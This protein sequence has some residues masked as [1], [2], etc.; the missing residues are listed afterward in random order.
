MNRYYLKAI[1][2]IFTLIALVGPAYCFGSN[3]DIY[4]DNRL[5]GHVS[6]EILNITFVQFGGAVNYEIESYQT[7]KIPSVDIVRDG[8]SLTFK[9]SGCC[10]GSVIQEK[11]V[12][13]ADLIEIWKKLGQPAQVAII[14]DGTGRST[15]QGM[16]YELV[17]TYGSEVP[18]NFVDVKKVMQKNPENPFMNF[19]DLV[20]NKLANVI[21]VEK[22]L[23]IKR[24]EWKEMIVPAGNADKQITAADFS[25]YILGL[26]EKYDWDSVIRARDRLE[27][28]WIDWSETSK[29]APFRKLIR[30]IISRAAVILQ[31]YI[32]DEAH[33][34]I[35]HHPMYKFFAREKATERPQENSSVSSASA[36]SRNSEEL[37]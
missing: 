21:S 5:T 20:T 37:V 13:K 30:S 33:H 8:S 36:H 17:F 12:L 15:E 11:E 32:Q 18:K 19:P 1:S 3:F 31:Q 7:L 34:L 27:C 35:N 22:F 29:K 14:V 2:A 10:L 26:P 23:S 24:Y 16:A 4:I 25:R 9:G 6:K 28:R